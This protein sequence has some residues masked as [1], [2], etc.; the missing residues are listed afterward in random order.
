MMLAL[1][2]RFTFA[3]VL[4]ATVV[5]FGTSLP[6]WWGGHFGGYRLLAHMAASGVVVIGLPLYAILRWTDWLSSPIPTRGSAWTFWA[7]I[8]SGF[9]T[10]ASM[11]ACMMPSTTTSWMVALIDFHGWIGATM[12]V[13]A[14]AHLATLR[15]VDPKQPAT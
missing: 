2:R 7:L 9:L 13:A 8:L 5:L 11:Y 15:R 1:I 4:I 10:I 6:T 3:G 12:A 14:I